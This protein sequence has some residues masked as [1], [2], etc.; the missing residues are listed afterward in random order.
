MLG[1]IPMVLIGVLYLLFEDFVLSDFGTQKPTSSSKGSG[2][3]TS[4]ILTGIQVCFG[5]SENAIRPFAVTDTS[6]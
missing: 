6:C 2:N 3:L 1:G 5:Q 4:R